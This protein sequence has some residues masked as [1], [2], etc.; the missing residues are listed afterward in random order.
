MWDEMVE[1]DRT[2]RIIWACAC[3]V[4]LVFGTIMAMAAVKMTNLESYRWSMA[5]SIMGM[6]SVV[7][8]PFGLW[9]FTLLKKPEIKEA[10]EYKPD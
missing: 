10:Y 8:L 3:G 2:T 4:V 7:A 5:A 6:I 1:D 9:A